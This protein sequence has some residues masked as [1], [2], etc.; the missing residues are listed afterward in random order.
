METFKDKMLLELKRLIGYFIFFALYFCAFT[1]YSR[2]LLEKYQIEAVFKYGYAIIEALILAKLIILGES[3]NLGERFKNRPLIIPT[4]YK[5]AVFS[6][7]VVV[8]TIIE[9]FVMGF[10]RGKSSETILEHLIDQG[11]YEIAAKMVV[12]LFVFILFFAFTET[13]KAL[14]G[15]KLYDLFMRKR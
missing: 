13:A 5:T 2:L 12:M 8:M 3:F 11:F 14:G 7:F 9:E 15:T 4:I 1:F 6:L 10:I